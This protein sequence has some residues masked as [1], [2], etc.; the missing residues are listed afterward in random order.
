MQ[1]V[2]FVLIHLHRWVT[3]SAAKPRV[4][5]EVQ[6]LRHLAASFG[7]SSAA[8]PFAAVDSQHLSFP[9]SWAKL[10]DS[11][12]NSNWEFLDRKPW[13]SIWLTDVRMIIC[14]CFFK[15][16]FWRCTA[17]SFYHSNLGQDLPTPRLIPRKC[18]LRLGWVRWDWVRD[19]IWCLTVLH[20]LS[21]GCAAGGF[22]QSP[23]LLQIQFAASWAI[24][25]QLWLKGLWASGTCKIKISYLTS[26]SQK[27]SFR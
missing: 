7:L 27:I 3:S 16:I 5:R 8:A 12:K 18:C 1:I 10:S 17:H 6:S 25:S 2:S 19:G 9:L 23:E 24:M 20:A 13:L 15:R 14:K 21:L 22:F 4:S 11:S 26:F